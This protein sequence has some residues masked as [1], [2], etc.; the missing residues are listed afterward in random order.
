MNKIIESFLNTHIR[1]YSI[2]EFEKEIAFEHFINRCVVNKYSVDRFDPMDIM[3]DEGEKGIDGVA[4]VVNDRIIMTVDELDSVVKDNADLEVKFVFIQ[5]KTSDKFSGDEIGT[6][7]YGV[8]AFFEEESM[9]PKTNEKMEKMIA[10]KDLIYQKSID[11]VKNPELDLYYVCCGKWDDNN[12]LQNRID[13]EIKPLIESQ[14]FSNVEFYK[15]DSDKISIAYKELKK[16]ISRTFLMERRISFPDI[17]GAKQSFLGIVSCQQFISL[18]TDNDGKMLTNIFEDNVRDFQGYNPVNNEIRDTINDTEDQRRFAL[19]NNGITI[20]AKKVDVTGDNVEIYDYQI[21]NGC[22]TSYVLFD[23]R[24]MIKNGTYIIVKVIEVL[25]EELSDRVIYTTNRQT[26]VKSEA[27]TSTKHFHKEL[28]DYY[29]ALV[30]EFGLYYERRSKQYDMQDNIR[31]ANV[32]SL[33]TQTASY[34]ATFLSEPQSTHR[35][36]GELLNAYKNRLYLDTDASEPYYIAAYFNFFLDKLFKEGKIEKKYRIF[37]FHLMLGMKI[38]MTDTNI[39]CGKARKQKNICEKIF[40]IIRTESELQKYFETAFMCLQQTISDSRINDMDQHRSKEF[41][42]EYILLLNKQKN[43]V[44]STEYLKKGDVVH[45]TVSSI[46]EYFVHVEIKTQ[47]TRNTGEIHISKLAKK[48][49]EKCE[50]AVEIGDIFQAK[51]ISD[52]YFDSKYGW[53]LT[54]LF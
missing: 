4:I 37:K 18:L 53:S 31:K 34:V 39:I 1:E 42:T 32:V 54:R 21:V 7:I 40:R 10:I 29:N 3:T 19:L 51:I 26:E 17:K 13:I 52:D 46:S 41:T 11:M 6:F 22:Q 9:R 35:Y 27:F 20:V 49:I 25:S 23:N 44:D 15:Y 33:A 38:L 48:W 36:Y 43:A 47:D 30:G 24:E 12:G 16:K 2:E 5:S 28:Q 14:N 8:K 45:C 50:D